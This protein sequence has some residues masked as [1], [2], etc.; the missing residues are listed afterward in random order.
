MSL[1]SGSK[2]GCTATLDNLV[3][4]SLMQRMPCTITVVHNYVLTTKSLLDIPCMLQAIVTGK[5]PLENLSDHLAN[6]G[7]NNGFAAATK[8]VP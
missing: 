5:G 8:F 6:P 7:T 4:L 2:F 3:T 1:A